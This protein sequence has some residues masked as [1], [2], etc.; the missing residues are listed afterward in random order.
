MSQDQIGLSARFTQAFAYAQ[1]LHANQ[2]RKGGSIPYLSHLMS[3]AALVLEDNGTEEDAIAALLHDA[4]EDQGGVETLEHIRGQ[5]GDTIAGYVDALS[6]AR[7][8]PKPP[9]RQ[10]K[11]QYFQQLRKAPPSVL[12]IAISDKLHNARSIV[13][14]SEGYGDRI[15]ERFKTGKSGTIWYYRTFMQLCQEQG[16][17]SR[18]LPELSLVVSRLESI[19]E[20][21][22]EE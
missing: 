16:C 8:T 20:K 19:P 7:G 10:R 22:F 13:L 3:V 2:Y 12:H 4:V 11:L 15:W 5:F 21:G 18:H 9:W 1:Q 6:D 17:T 14:D